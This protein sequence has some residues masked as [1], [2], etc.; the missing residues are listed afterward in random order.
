MSFQIFVKSINGK[1]RTLDVNATDSIASIKQQ[2]AE[3][4]GV[5][6]E[7]QRLIF[8]GKNLDDTKTLQDYNINA[9]S[10]IHLVLRVKGGTR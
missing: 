3:K 5:S 2:M 8:A 7:E 6:A 9:E 10:T 4:E 1:S